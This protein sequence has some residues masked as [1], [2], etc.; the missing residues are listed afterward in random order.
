MREARIIL[1]LADNDG[2]PVDTA[3]EYLKG[4]LC[5]LFGG[6][7]ATPVMGGWMDDSGRLYEDRSIAYDVAMEDTYENA[8]K[9]GSIAEIAGQMAKQ[10]AMYVRLP[11][12]NVQILN[13]EPA[14]EA[15]KAA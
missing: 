10:L 4:R 6:F 13:I 1:P 12:G 15:A 3:H 11:N 9:V 8:R 5:R 7:T 14:A 2:K